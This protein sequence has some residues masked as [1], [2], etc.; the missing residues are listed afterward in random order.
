MEKCCC[1]KRPVAAAIV[2]SL[3]KPLISPGVSLGAPLIFMGLM[4]DGD[5]VEGGNPEASLTPL[6]IRS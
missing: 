4:G 1:A 2:D 5:C 6:F 3:H